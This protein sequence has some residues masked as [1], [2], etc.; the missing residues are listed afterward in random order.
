MIECCNCGHV[1]L[2]LRQVLKLTFI[3]MLSFKTCYNPNLTFNNMQKNQPKLLQWMKTTHI[4]VMLCMNVNV[5]CSHNTHN[6]WNLIKVSIEL[7]ISQA[8][9]QKKC[10]ELK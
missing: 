5:T 2:P 8:I 3:L 6:L 10:D 4:Q 9:T 1:S 7:Q